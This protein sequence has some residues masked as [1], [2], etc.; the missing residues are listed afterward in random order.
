MPVHYMTV[1]AL[2]RNNGDTCAALASPSAA[3]LTHKVA[4]VLGMLR[5]SS[6]S[7]NT[8]ASSDAHACRAVLTYLQLALALAAPTAV[9][10]GIEAR[11]WMWHAE[12]RRRAGLP[13]ERGWQA[14]FYSRISS[15]LDGLDWPYLAVLGWVA[16][17]V[18]YELAMAIA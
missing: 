12:E 15:L 3:R 13:P 6:L 4:Q 1:M 16:L 17:G 14:A 18:L 2:W 7:P 11:L 9:Q 10:A 5:F 8:A